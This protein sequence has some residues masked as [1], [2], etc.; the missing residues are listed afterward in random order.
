MRLLIVY[1]GPFHVNSAIQAFHFGERA[2]DSGLG[3]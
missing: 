2:D 1:F 3:R